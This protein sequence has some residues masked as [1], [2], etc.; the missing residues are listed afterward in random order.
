MLMKGRNLVFI[1]L[2]VISVTVEAGAQTLSHQ[3]LVPVAGVVSDSKVS[4]SQTGGET[5]VELVG[6]TWY[7]FTQG[8]QQPVIK[9]IEEAVPPGSGV[10]VYP[11][12]ATDF[13]TVELFGEAA[14]TFRVEIINSAGVITDSFRK[15][16][17]NNFWLKDPLNIEHLKRGFYIV[18][19]ISE[20]GLIS[21]SFKIEK[22]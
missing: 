1:S 16:C 21:R 7:Q 13:I 11:N 17:G 4:Y 19:V 3:V 2:I 12:P 8:F 5:A 20:D 18:R 14:R 6:C 22:M 10:K 15:E 9:N